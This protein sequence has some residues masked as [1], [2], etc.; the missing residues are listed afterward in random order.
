[1][2]HYLF[3]SFSHVMSFV[4]VVAKRNEKDERIEMEKAK[5]TENLRKTFRKLFF[6]YPDSTS[7]PPLLDDLLQPFSFVLW[8]RR[9]FLFPDSLRTNYPHT[10]LEK[11]EE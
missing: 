9:Y 1:M 8:Y 4:N 6:H 2:E 10:S 3:F 7:E 5:L 11:R